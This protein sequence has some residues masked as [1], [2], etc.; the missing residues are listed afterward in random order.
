MEETAKEL[1]VKELLELVQR[2]EGEFIIH[3]EPGG[4]ETNADAGKGT[5]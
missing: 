2:Q 4:E 3:I 5:L 1:T